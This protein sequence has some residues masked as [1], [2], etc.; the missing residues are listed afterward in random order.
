MN[1]VPFSLSLNTETVV[2]LI[3]LAGVI[4][5]IGYG[6]A[7]NKQATGANSAVNNRA[8]DEPAIYEMVRDTYISITKMEGWKDGYAG[9]PLDD[10]VK[11]MKFV[12]RVDKMHDDIVKIQQ[13]LED[14][15][16]DIKVYGCPVKLRKTDVCL[17]ELEG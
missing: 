14:T 6:R 5:S 3:T 9:G 16:E 7:A 8:P 15:R 12:E 2:A 13:C 17:N 10:G 11:V 1:E 4:L